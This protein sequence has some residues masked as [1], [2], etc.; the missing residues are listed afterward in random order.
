MQDVLNELVQQD[1]RTRHLR[2]MGWRFKV[3]PSGYASRV[4]TTKTVLVPRKA[5]TGCPQEFR[6]AIDSTY[7]RN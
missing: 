7:H 5:L 3:S 4:R 1:A 2:S 6:R